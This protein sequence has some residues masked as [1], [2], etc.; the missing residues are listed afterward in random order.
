MD[1]D[2][3]KR[4]LRQLKK[5]ESKIRFGYGEENRYT[6]YVW[7]EYFSTRQE[8]NQNIKYPLPKLLMMDK[9]AMKEIFEE[10][11]YCVYFQKYKENGLSF[12]DIY[13]PGV[14]SVLGLKP[15]AS[16]EDVRK[17]F[18]ELAKK[19]HP[20]MG[21]SSQKMIELLDAYHKLLDNT[22]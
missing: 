17:R 3:L 14:L 19:Y 8:N 5:V 20:D 21:G 1:I 18:R 13:E 15:G 16:A 7:D 4:K 2:E 11:F 12:D 6:K 22:P 10:Y 9:Q